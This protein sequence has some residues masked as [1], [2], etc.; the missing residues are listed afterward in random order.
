MT[1][2]AIL[3]LIR[4]AVMLMALG[5]VF[6]R[7]FSGISHRSFGL[8]AL[9]GVFVGLVG[10]SV[11]SMPLTLAQGVIFDT[12]SVLLSISGLFFG[13]V[14]TLAAAAMTIALRL[15]QG[16]GG[17]LMGVLVILATS[18]LGLIWR[19]GRRDRLDRITG[20][21]L[22]V[23]G[24]T[25]HV[26]MLLLM[27]TLP[28][29]LAGAALRSLSLPIM[30]IYPLGTVLLGGLLVGQQQRLSANDA[31]K[32]SER[33]HRL[34]IDHAPTGVLVADGEGRYLEVNAAACRITGFS[35]EEI[36]RM[37]VMDFSPPG[38]EENALAHFAQ[39]QETGSASAI[40]PFNRRDGSL[41]WWSV[42]AVGLGGDRFI[43]FATDVS[44]LKRL[45]MASAES[46]RQL[47]QAQALA[48]T[49][50]WEI[51]LDTGE[52]TASPEARRIYGF[53]DQALTVEM[54]KENPQ[55]EHRDRLNRA[56]ADLVAGRAPYE[57]EF[58]ITRPGD[59]QIVDV[60]SLATYDRERRVVT[61]TLQ[62]ISQRKIIEQTLRD[63]EE[64]FRAVFEHAAIGIAVVGLDGRWIRANDRLCGI[65]G[66]SPTEI[67]E[68]TFQDITHPEDLEEDLKLAG[69]CLAGDRSTYMLEK[70][71]IRKEG[72]EVW[73]DLTVSLIRDARGE[74]SYF[75]AVV[76]D[77]SVRKQAEWDRDRAE[78]DLR[79]AQKME[80]VGRLA[81]GI[82]HDFNNML[83]VILG[84]A[85]L[86]LQEMP[87]DGTQ[88]R[89]VTE[90]QA[91]ARRSADL[92]GQLLAFSRKQAA[93]P[94]VID[95]NQAVAG[96]QA[97]L[98]RLIGEAVEIVF[99][100]DPQLWLIRM[101]PSQLDQILANLTAN[102]RDAIQGVGRVVIST[103]NAKLQD[104]IS[105]QGERIPA[106][107]YVALTFSDSGKGI[108]E[109]DL[110]KI[111]EPFY[112]TKPI[113][114]GTGLG[115]ATVYGVVKQ[116]GGHIQ[117][118]S[119]IQQG[120]TFTIHLPRFVGSFDRVEIP[121]PQEHSSGGETLL[122]VEDEPQLLELAVRML[123]K[124]G[125][126]VLQA[127][128]PE[129]ALRIAAEHPGTIDL[130]VTD[131]IMPQMDGFQLL[132]R[133]RTVRPGQR[134]LLMSGY[135]DDAIARHG[136]MD[137]DLKFLSKPFTTNDIHAAV[138]GALSGA[139]PDRIPPGVPVG[140]TGGETRQSG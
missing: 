107:D 100:P 133:I 95:L 97:M 102:A 14:P 103:A 59:G 26:V 118:E 56:L 38:A 113:E 5:L 13:L 42:Q 92:T 52:V 120:T 80:A 110:P 128:T 75:I 12:R 10:M 49:G 61:G 119:S 2:E 23:F 41:G 54:I 112:T 140:G 34:Y 33:K 132:E 125:Y 55:P 70:R 111:F 43:G 17:A 122:V 27:F 25:V 99:E 131:V 48:S 134:S 47:N 87:E 29:T 58:R 16:G 98:D 1:F 67:Q 138:Q 101:D 21:E 46:E 36:L 3:A 63:S 126:V 135:P 139:R 114:K 108:A 78:A 69:E 117:V 86:T 44:E 57:Q 37:R 62:D 109:A 20:M 77:I 137:G 19:R 66:Y 129:L 65:V 74:P 6:D 90:I 94:S 136:T 82:A 60:H 115:L 9:A 64:R 124:A 4:N 15:Y 88:R 93:T 8:R 35:R 79:Q 91:A 72:R 28:G 22:Y 89:N 105:Q 32:E 121:V 104:G 7:F 39:L 53:Q 31:V 30:I 24:I 106:G 127:G 123:E 73:I 85:D 96:Q 11:M 76:S 84:Y 130:V 68:I 116:N 83:N 50:N 45:E 71:Y 51:H 40:L 81:G 18:L